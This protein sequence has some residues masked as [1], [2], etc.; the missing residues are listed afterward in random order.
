[1]AESMRSVDVPENEM[2][3]LWM[4]VRK[5]FAWFDYWSEHQNGR[6]CT[7]C[8]V[9]G[10]MLVDGLIASRPPRKKSAMN[11]PL[12]SEV[13]EVRYIVSQARGAF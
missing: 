10:A 5:R 13:L 9:Q 2:R 4:V 8:R 1:M 6:R 7:L 11:G 12:R 3:Y